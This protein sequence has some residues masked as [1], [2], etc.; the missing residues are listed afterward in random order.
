MEIV[1]RVPEHG[2]GEFKLGAQVIVRESQVAVFF[3]DG[4]SLDTF[5]PGRHT[6]STLNLPLVGKAVTDRIFGESPFKAEV[7]FVNQKVFL[8]LRWG[9]RDPI[10]YRDSEL[11][12]V[13]LRARGS[14]SMRVTDPLVFVNRVCGTQGLFRTDDIHGHL[15]TVVLSAL[16]RVLGEQL[17]TIF[18]LPVRYQDVALATRAR[19]FEQFADLGVEL[20]DFLVESITPPDEVQQRVDERAGLAAVGDLDRYLK[21]KSALALGDLANQPGG[22]AG[23]GVAA[24][25][26]LGMGLALPGML[27][28]SLG[29]PATADQPSSAPAS[30]AQ[31]ASAHS[32]PSCHAEAPP[33]SRFC[34]RCGTS[35]VANACSSCGSDLAPE[36]KF[37][38]RC[39][40]PAAADREPGGEA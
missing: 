37:C 21:Y 8:N 33:D 20:V 3:R 25:A 31:P 19:I 24:G 12:T 40:K 16:A 26:G 10:A 39:G 30:P 35:I 36:M 2:S 9:T 32:C 14:F 1:R 34:P 5:E 15:K 27:Q 29:K 18:D 13:R 4:K 28:G 6:L 22:A 17:T 38:P 11:L 23:A 7:Y